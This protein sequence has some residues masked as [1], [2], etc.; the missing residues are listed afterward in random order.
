ML[1]L[2][3]KKKEKPYVILFF[4][5]NGTGKTMTIGKFAKMLRDNGYTVVMAAGDTFRAAAIEQ[6]EVHATNLKVPIIKQKKGADSAAVIFDSIKYAKAHNIDVVL[7]DTAGRSHTNT[8]LMDELRKIVRVAKP[9]FKV[10]VGDSL[11]VNDAAEQAKLFSDAVGIDGS[12]LTK[13]DTDPKGGACL[14]VA[15]MTKQPILYLG[16]GQKYEDLIDFSSK[17][18]LDKVF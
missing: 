14:S 15:Y 13:V 4:G 2:V 3:E 1:K 16:N 9:D 7:A 12:V 17:W 6:L 5:F 10:F 18:F 8:N 11:T